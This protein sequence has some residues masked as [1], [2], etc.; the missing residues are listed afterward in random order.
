LL[1]AAT[2]GTAASILLPLPRQDNG[3]LS[4]TF[5]YLVPANRGS[6]SMRLQHSPALAPDSWTDVEIPGASATI[7]GVEFF[8]TPL[9]GGNLNQIKAVVPAG[10]T[11]RV[12]VRLSATVPDS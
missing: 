2:P 8:I 1:G 9:P 4:V 11:G 10:P 12:F 7:N 5:N 6:Y 3:A